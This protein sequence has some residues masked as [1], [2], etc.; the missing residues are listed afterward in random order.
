[1]TRHAVMF[2]NDKH[3][4]KKVVL[5]DN[6]DNCINEDQYKRLIKFL[7]GKKK[8]ECGGI[9]SKKN[10]HKITQCEPS[11]YLVIKNSI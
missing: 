2:Y 11:K 8:C 9:N 4:T 7:C 5:V 3:N 1:M 6:D 10:D